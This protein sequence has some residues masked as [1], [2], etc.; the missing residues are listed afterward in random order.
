MSATSQQPSGSAGDLHEADHGHG[1][2]T[3]AL[4]PAGTGVGPI[5]GDSAGPR[6]ALLTLLRPQQGRL[7][8]AIACGLLDQ[9]LALAA[10]LL[11]A[12]LVARA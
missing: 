3:P 5:P 8:A 9:A 4:D 12:A 10:A 7:T 1:R 11:G 2:G 6:G